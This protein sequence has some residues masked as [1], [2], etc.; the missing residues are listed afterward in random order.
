M[1]ELGGRIVVEESQ[2]MT[3]LLYE[4]K[5]QNIKLGKNVFVFAVKDYDLSKIN[6]NPDLQNQL[7]DVAGSKDTMRV[8]FI[9]CVSEGLYTDNLFYLESYVRR[10]E[11]IWSLHGKDATLYAMRFYRENEV[12]WIQATLTLK[13]NKMVGLQ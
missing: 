10:K 8:A 11:G 13:C 12:Q 5:F 3:R 4:S 6:E 2:F 1:E 7:D 9:G